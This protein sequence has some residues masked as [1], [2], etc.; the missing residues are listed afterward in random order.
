MKKTLLA[1]LA[2]TLAL[3][4]LPVG[5]H[6]A[7]VTVRAE[8]LKKT[9]VP[10][11]E[12]T[13][14]TKR[15]AHEGSTCAG[16][17]VLDALQ[18]ATRG[19]WDGSYD[20]H[21][22]DFLIGDILGETPAQP[23]YWTIWVNHRS[24]STGACSTPVHDGDEVLFYVC[25]GAKPPDFA[26]PSP[27]DL[28][29]PQRVRHGRAFTVRVVSYAADGS[30]SRVA[31]ATVRAGGRSVVTAGDGTARVRAPERGGAL[32]VRATKT[33]LV[34]VAADVC[35]TSGRDGRC[36]STDRIAPRV[37]IG[38]IRPGHHFATRGP[39]TL[40]GTAADAGGLRGVALRLTR[41]RDHR[42]TRYSSR[43]ERFAA[44]PCSARGGFF[45]IGADEAWSYLLPVRLGRGDYLLEA[46]AS[47]R[48]GNRATTRVRFSVG[49][50]GR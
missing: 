10:R 43:T 39:R 17:T 7:D 26:C 28:R 4:V 31:G 16:N 46:R 8:G 44:I 33:G 6:A 14:T 27:L 32:S 19:R 2:G 13:T 34:R 42:C 38:G 41:T 40:A 20:A 3:G 5:A 45:A 11:T 35:L 30:A 15:V 18:R 9:L 24:S 12:V 23:D 1:P 47:D 37:R 48:R 36:G 29:L 25:H 49:A 22:R 50:A 21:F